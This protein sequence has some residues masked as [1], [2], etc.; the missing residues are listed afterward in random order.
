MSLVFGLNIALNHC[1]VTH[2]MACVERGE[3]LDL[4]C[5]NFERGPS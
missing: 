1:R 2:G 3:A 5:A 4:T